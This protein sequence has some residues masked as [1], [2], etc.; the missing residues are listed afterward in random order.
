[1][2][3]R[4]DPYDTCQDCVVKEWCGRRS[5][6]VPLPADYPLN[7]EC[8]GYILL[9]RALEL[10]G[11]PPEYRYA[12]LNTF[13]IDNDNQNCAKTIIAAMQYPVELVESGT[14]LAFLHPNKGTGKTFAA[15]AIAN[16]YIYKT[17]MNPEKFDFENPLA[18][19]VEFGDWSNEIRRA[20]QVG[21][22]ELYDLMYSRI[23]KMKDVPLLILD[24][25]GS[26]RITDV[27]RDLTYD[28][29]N[30]RK[31]Q[32]LSTIYTSNFVDTVLRQDNYLGE[33]IVSRMLYNTRVLMLGGRDRRLS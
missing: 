20:H 26:G 3:Q 13:V 21:D 30:R 9:E 31:V 10:A 2:T 7:P 14:N 17:C 29:I 33:M 1:M 16:E 12:S 4:K 28:V 6:K 11:I 23:D 24:D 27:I 15:C 22:P 8:S 5:G 18:L 25:I 19:Y 32:K